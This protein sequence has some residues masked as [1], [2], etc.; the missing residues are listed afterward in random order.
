MP[1]FRIPRS[2]II[3]AFFGWAIQPPNIAEG[4]MF[5]FPED[6]SIRAQ[7]GGKLGNTK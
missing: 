3:D 6:T 7:V 5:Y 1:D 2:Q 4:I